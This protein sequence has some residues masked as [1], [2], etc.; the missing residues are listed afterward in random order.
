VLRVACEQKG[1]ARCRRRQDARFARRWSSAAGPQLAA[2]LD[3]QRERGPRWGG[4]LHS[5][6]R[7]QASLVPLRSRHA[8]LA[9]EDERPAKRGQRGPDA[10]ERAALPKGWLLSPADRATQVWPAEGS[11]TCF[12]TLR[13]SRLTLRHRVARA[14]IREKAE[15]RVD[16]GDDQHSAGLSRGELQVPLPYLRARAPFQR[17]WSLEADGADETLPWPTFAVRLA[18]HTWAASPAARHRLLAWGGR[19]WRRWRP[20]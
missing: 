9:Q 17:A 6:G 16:G 15:L 14:R 10:P 11:E 12:Q 8:H 2:P 20:S 3:E 7:A 13:N 18:V 4:V 5:R 19:A 1:R